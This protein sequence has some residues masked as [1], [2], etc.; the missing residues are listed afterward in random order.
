MT[1]EQKIEY[2]VGIEHPATLMCA[3]IPYMNKEEIEKYR[4]QL[5]SHS[6]E[7]LSTAYLEAKKE[8]ERNCFFNSKD[9][10]TIDI[11]YWSD[12]DEWQGQ[13]LVALSLLRNPDIV[14][15]K[16]M[17]KVSYSS[18]PFIDKWQDMERLIGCAIDSRKIRSSGVYQNMRGRTVKPID[19][20]KW[21]EN[22]D[23]IKLPKELIKEVKRKSGDADVDNSSLIKNLSEVMKSTN[24][25]CN[26]LENENKALKEEKPLG[27]TERKS[28]L[29]MVY[30]M[31][32][33]G[34]SWDP[35][36]SKSATPN[37]IMQDVNKNSNHP[38]ND[39]TVRKWL[40]EAK[41]LNDQLDSEGY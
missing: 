17:N 7:H 18:S 35:E 39:D 6:E 4:K 36:A 20:I 13:A 24:D 12:L 8:E 15:T 23:N 11:S 40:K 41:K 22:K 25:R 10:R 33:G 29:K 16:S 27:V 9:A 21:A 5:E 37:E 28:L 14:N 34:Y 2:L 30:G 1:K 3:D 38:I 32:I 31:A 26:K 19:F